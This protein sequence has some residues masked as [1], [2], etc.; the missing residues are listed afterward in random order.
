MNVQQAVGK[1]IV[2]LCNQHNL[3]INRLAVISSVPPSTLKNIVNGISKNPG[4]ATIKKL[5]DGLDITLIDFFMSDIF[6]DLKQEI[7]FRGVEQKLS[8]K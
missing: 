8:G 1:R 6:R 3:S 2:E 4:I 5:C 7:K